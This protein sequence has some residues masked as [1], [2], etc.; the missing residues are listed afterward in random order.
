LPGTLSGVTTHR[1]LGVPDVKL[2]AG[3]IVF[4]TIQR[5][6]FGETGDGELRDQ[7]DSGER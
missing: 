6:R 7:L 3:D 2:G 5:G 1:G 4:P